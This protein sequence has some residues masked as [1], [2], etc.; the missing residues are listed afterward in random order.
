MISDCIYITSTSLQVSAA[1]KAVT[2][3]LSTYDY[4]II[5]LAN[6]GN[7]MQEFPGNPTLRPS[8]QDL[9][10]QLNNKTKA[11]IALSLRFPPFG[12]QKN[13]KKKEQW[14]VC[15]AWMGMG[16]GGWAGDGVWMPQRGSERGGEQG[17][18]CNRGRQLKKKAALH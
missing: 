8:P 12:Q 13:N 4:E 17:R 14:Q 16:R 5:I 7:V 1:N 3:L 11:R 2:L 9:C 6:P 18:R 15:G 10:H